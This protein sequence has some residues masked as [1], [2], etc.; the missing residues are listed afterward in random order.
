MSSSKAFEFSREFS[1]SIAGES[2]A[3]AAF[4]NGSLNPAISSEAYSIIHKITVADF[5]GDNLDDIVLFYGDVNTK[6]R[7]YLSDSDGS[8]THADWMPDGGERRL[9]RNAVVEDINGDGLKDLIGFTAPH[10]TFQKQLGDY[11]D[12][13]EPDLILINTGSKFRLVEGLA[14]TYHHGGS[15]GNLDN[16]NLIDILGVSEFPNWHWTFSPR[17]PLLQSAPGEFKAAEWG[18]DNVFP[19]A[20]LSDIRIGDLNSD[21]LDDVVVTIN[22]PSQVENDRTSS[23]MDSYETGV[24]SYSFGVRGKSFAQTHWGV[25]R[26]LR[27]N[28]KV[29]TPPRLR[30]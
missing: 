20:V 14:E 3:Y 5:N 12:W 26:E 8:F 2:P 29:V 28:L 19:E 15:V 27:V 24:V 1:S 18:L 11:W 7:L 10:G 23:P 9:V 21:G 16:D 6:P 22:Y 30:V 17:T 13:D 25:I 4:T